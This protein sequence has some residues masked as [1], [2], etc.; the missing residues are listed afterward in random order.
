LKRYYLQIK[1]RG[2]HVV[3]PSSEVRKLD[4]EIVVYKRL[5]KRNGKKQLIYSPIPPESLKGALRH[6]AYVA[7]KALNLVKVY[8]SLFG[9]DV[10]RKSSAENADEVLGKL[11]PETKES[12]ISI[13]L[14]EGLT[15]QQIEELIEE[16]PRIRIDRAKGSVKE[17]ALA[18]TSTISEEFYLK[19]ELL[20]EGEL[21]SDEERLLRS[22]V[23]LLKGWAIGGWSSLGFGLIEEVKF[24]EVGSS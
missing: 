2:A 6:V 21:S 8:E 18:Y 10:S 23:N 24:E 1:I 14:V 9:S 4:H 13:S 16:R 3:Q 12:R 22:A 7:A 17:E 5:V 15:R 11:S 19:Y 20:V